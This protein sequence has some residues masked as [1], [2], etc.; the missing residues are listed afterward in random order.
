[1]AEITRL[2]GGSDCMEL[3]FVEREATPEP[4]MK[5]GIGLHLEGLSLSNTISELERFGVDRSRSTVHNWVQKA[6][7]QPD[8]G[9]CPDHVAVDDTVI[10]IDDQQ[11]WLYAVTRNLRFLV[12]PRELALVNAIDPD[13]NEFLHVKHGTAQHLGLSE[14]FLGDGAPWLQTALRRHGLRFQHETHGNRTAIER[15]YKEIKRRP[16][17]FGNHFRH[18]EP[19]TAET[20]LQAQAFCQ[21]QRI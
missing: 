8:E 19:A 5:L 3:D 10:Q 6:G 15:L 20:W 14:L 4:L 17:Q 9:R 11:Y 1:M 2:S 12:G 7:L 16:D 13:T 21:N 18:V